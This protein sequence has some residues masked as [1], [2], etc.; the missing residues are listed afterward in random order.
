MRKAFRQTNWF[1]KG[2]LDAEAAHEAAGQSDGLHPGASDLLPPEDRYLDDGSVT[3]D[4]SLA[5]SLRT[6]TTV[7]MPIAAKIVAV[8]AGDDVQQLMHDLK[9]SQRRATAF[10]VGAFAATLAAVVVAM[11]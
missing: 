2:A 11:V 9:R 1:K 4:D 5:Y 7:A 3:S 8:S 6:G 10:V